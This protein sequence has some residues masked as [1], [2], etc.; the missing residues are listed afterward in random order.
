M[1]SWPWLTNTPLTPL[2]RFKIDL[3]SHDQSLPVPSI[4]QTQTQLE[5]TDECVLSIH[6]STVRS[7][8]NNG[9]R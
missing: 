8:T 6:Y 4:Q 3:F 5:R 9:M 2:D 1:A 7:T